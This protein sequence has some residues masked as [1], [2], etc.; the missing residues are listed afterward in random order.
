[1]KNN[2]ENWLNLRHTIDKIYVCAQFPFSVNNFTKKFNPSLAKPPLKFSNVLAKLQNYTW[3]L[4]STYMRLHSIITL[5]MGMETLSASLV[6]CE[7]SS[8][9]TNDIVLWCFTRW[10]SRYCGDFRHYSPRVTSL[11]SRPPPLWWMGPNWL[12]DSTFDYIASHV[13]L[14]YL[15]EIFTHCVLHTCLIKII[16]DK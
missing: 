12:L 10:T 3:S 6:L 13:F 5:S 16:F 9:R 15:L 7:F 1:M 14:P 2:W 11:Q 8:Q 4:R